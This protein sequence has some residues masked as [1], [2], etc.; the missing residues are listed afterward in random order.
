MHREEDVSK[1]LSQNDFWCISILNLKR[2]V[3][4]TSCFLRMA[5]DN[6]DD[7]DN[8]QNDQHKASGLFNGT[9]SPNCEIII[10]SG[11]VSSQWD[12]RRL[13][14]YFQKFIIQSVSEG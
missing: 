5:N 11:R 2:R 8:F 7:A 9:D 10:Q 6:D 12:S 13:L 1:D 3:I 14:I 4:I